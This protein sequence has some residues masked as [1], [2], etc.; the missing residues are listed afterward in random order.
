MLNIPNSFY[1]P[2]C[3]SSLLNISAVICPNNSVTFAAPILTVPRNKS[4]RYN[5][6]ASD[7]NHDSLSFEL[8]P[9]EGVAGYTFPPGFT[10]DPIAG[11]IFAAAPLDTVGAYGFAVK[12]SEWRQGIKIGYVIREFALEITPDADTSYYF[13]PPPFP[14]DTSGNFTV[15]VNAGAF[16]AF[17]ITYIDG[18]STPSM[19]VYSEAML[20]QTAPLIT[21][22]TT[23]SNQVT[24]FISWTPDSL[25]PRNHPYIF[26]FRGLFHERQTDLTVLIYITGRLM[27]TCY[28]VPHIGV[29]EIEFS[30]KNL[31]VYPNP[32]NSEL[33]IRGK[34]YEP[35]NRKIEI[36]SVHGQKVYESIPEPVNTDPGYP[37]YK[38][39][40]SRLQNGV[41]QLVTNYGNGTFCVIH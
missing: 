19:N 2:F 34:G 41:Y 27:D 20:L 6:A 23:V 40:V 8:V 4:Y 10:I 24:A 16:I 15:T 12:V 32:V 21:Y 18:D 1:V 29:D 22:D 30:K 3:V 39:D 36:Y 37:E 13:L 14:P 35:G 38:L 17:D 5:L 25:A 26:T 33:M 7:E 31:F 11:E 9:C 28:V